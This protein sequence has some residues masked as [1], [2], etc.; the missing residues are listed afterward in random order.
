MFLDTDDT[1]RIVILGESKNLHSI[2]DFGRTQKTE[3][4]SYADRATS[5]IGLIALAGAIAAA[6]PL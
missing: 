2:V 6:A 5:P 1:L 4:T 3:K